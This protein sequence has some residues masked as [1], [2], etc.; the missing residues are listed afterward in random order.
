MST[1]T[2]SF[3]VQS[4]AADPVGQ[5]GVSLI[6][7]LFYDSATAGVPT[8][9]LSLLQ[10]MRQNG[11]RFST[12]QTVFIGGAAAPRALIEAFQDEFGVSVRHAWGMTETSP[13]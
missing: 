9:W 2:A 6:Y 4:G 3:L 8:V 7:L 1:A 11:L 10:Y 5:N 13:L 12:L